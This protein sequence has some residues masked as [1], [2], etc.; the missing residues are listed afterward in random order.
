LDM[1]FPFCPGW[2]GPQSSCF[3]PSHHSWNNRHVLSSAT[4][5]DGGLTN[6]LPSLA[7]NHNSLIS[8]SQE[9]RIIRLATG[10]LLV[11]IIF[12]IVVLIRVRYL[13]IPLLLICFSLM[14]KDIE[15]FTHIF[16]PII[17]LLRRSV[18]WD[19]L[20]VLNFSYLF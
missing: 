3:T 17:F 16:W 4:G 10:V 18:H 7:L 11:I 2:H 15:H 9:D 20:P 1:L 14:V 6:F 19:H 13:T 12:I 8:A 5:W